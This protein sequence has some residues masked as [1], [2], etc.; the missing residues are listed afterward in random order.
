MKIATYKKALQ[1]KCPHI[2]FGLVLGQCGVATALAVTIISAIMAALTACSVSALSTNGIFKGKGG[3]F[4]LLTRSLGPALGMKAVLVLFLPFSRPLKKVHV[5]D[6]PRTCNA[7]GSICCM[8]VLSL[9]AMSA[10]ELAG[11]A[12]ALG[13]VVSYE[14]GIVHICGS[15]YKDQIAFGV[16]MLIILCVI[17]LISARAVHQIGTAFF[18]ILLLG[19]LSSFVGMLA[20]SAITNTREMYNTF[21]DNVFYCH[22]CGYIYIYI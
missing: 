10:I 8:Y 12:E 11:F 18:A 1:S 5:H 9:A 17:I 14:T 16:S 22:F 20:F 15:L 4:Q 2:R 3:A 7:G 19:Y 13:S 21:M 6:K